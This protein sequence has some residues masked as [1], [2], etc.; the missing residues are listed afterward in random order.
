MLSKIRQSFA[1]DKKKSYI[2]KKFVS[3]KEIGFIFRV[4]D[5]IIARSGINTVSEILVMEKISL[6]IP[7][8][9]GQRN[10]QLVNARLVEKLGVGIVLRQEDSTPEIIHAKIENIFENYQNYVKNS[11]AAKKLI[12]LGAAKK[13]VDIL[14]EYYGEARN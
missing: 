8:P 3:E 9:S 1:Q 11:K 6:L 5:L 7:L 10:E 12:K 4:A 14:M 2:L 13:V